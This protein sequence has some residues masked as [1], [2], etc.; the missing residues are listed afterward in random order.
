MKLLRH[1]LLV[2]ACCA[3]L[4]AEAHA[5]LVVNGGF[6]TGDFSGWTV[7]G[8][9]SF[10]GVVDSGLAHTG[11]FAAILGSPDVT[12]EQ[13]LTTDPGQE[14][15]LDLY[16]AVSG[17][18]PNSNR[19]VASI[20]GNPVIGPLTNID[21]Q[22]Y[23][24]LAATFIGTGSD[25]LDIASMNSDGFFLLDDVRVDPVGSVPEPGTLSLLG[26]GLAGLRL[27]RCRR[28]SLT[29]ERRPMAE[30]MI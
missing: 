7:T 28:R 20:G 9:D 26:I 11:T 6:E 21:N 25:K 1:V 27:F 4:S 16:L 29:I 24:L 30:S 14:Y 17:P 5:N 8:A 12:L 3:L 22:D 18:V 10:T 19:F 15:E 2:S 13:I 23:T